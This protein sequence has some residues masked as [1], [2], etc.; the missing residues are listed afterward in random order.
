MKIFDVLIMAAGKGAR[1]G[2][3]K[4]F[5]PL[6]ESTIIA[7]TINI[8]KG[9]DNIKNIII[10]F[11]PDMEEEE[12]REKGMFSDS[13]DELI[14]VKGS[15]KREESVLNGLEKA[16][17]EYVL[18]HDSVRPCCSRLLV[19][20]LMDKTVEKEAV[21]PGVNPVS[22]VKYMGDG[23]LKSLDRNKVYLVQTPQVFLT[24]KIKEAYYNRKNRDYTDS[25]SVA[26]DAGME[27]AVIEG[28]RNNIKITVPED[29]V[30]VKEIFGV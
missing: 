22:T 13:S 7:S 19:S 15:E 1:F 16:E 29:Y 17:A 26:E 10:V 6:G 20:R 4:Q 3:R 25:S 12:V 8:F 30:R 24:G 28:E 11:P 5:L 18:I 14:L 2:E 21:I 23:S 9:F 27:V